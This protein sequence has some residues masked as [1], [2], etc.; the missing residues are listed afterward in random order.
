MSHNVNNRFLEQDWTK[1]ILKKKTKSLPSIQKSYEVS[2][3]KKIEQVIN[4]DITPLKHKSYDPDFIMNVINYRQKHKLSQKQLA[5]KINK[6]EDVIKNI[7]NKTGIYDP[8][9]V[10][11]LK[12]LI[13][14]T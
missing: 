14:K 13:I 4:D 3:I 1:I 7:E 10:S 8:R 6:T 12:Q 2:K 5:N 11:L 9:I